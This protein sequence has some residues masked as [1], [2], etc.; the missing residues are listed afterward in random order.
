[1]N[2]AN[3]SPAKNEPE[4]TEEWARHMRRPPG[5]PEDAAAHFGG[6]FQAVPNNAAW[7]GDMDWLKSAVIIVFDCCP[8]GL[9]RATGALVVNRPTPV[10][11]GALGGSSPQDPFAENALFAGGSWEELSSMRAMAP[12]YWLHPFE[13][14]EACGAKRLNYSTWMGGDR[15]E[16]AR[17]T[18]NRGKSERPEAVRFFWRHTE[19]APGVFEAQLA[20]GA[21]KRLPDDAWLNPSDPEPVDGS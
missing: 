6:V 4:F 15:E 16:L 8:A 14:A 10:R 11:V 17:M 7:T 21:W 2:A 1:M 19:F 13:G 18:K 12:W 5:N 3:A 9:H 20:A